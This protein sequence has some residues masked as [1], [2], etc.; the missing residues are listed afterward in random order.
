[1]EASDSSES[2]E[3]TSRWTSIVDAVQKLYDVSVELLSLLQKGSSSEERDEFIRK[4]ESYLEDREQMIKTIQ[5]PYTTEQKTIG[6]KLIELN[7][8]ID[9]H[10]ASIKNDIQSEL[11]KLMNNKVSQEKYH[12]PYQKD[13]ISGLFYDKR[14]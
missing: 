5:L 12:D 6:M 2:S 1:M 8:K 10:I 13:T 7:K 14:N 3:A 4:I 11:R 9:H